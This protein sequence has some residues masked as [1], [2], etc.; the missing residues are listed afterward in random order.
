MG[1]PCGAEWG[2][3]CDLSPEPGDAGRAT[4]EPGA[5]HLFVARSD[6]EW[7]GRNPVGSIKT[8]VSPLCGDHDY[9]ELAP[10]CVRPGSHPV[11]ARQ[12]ISPS[13]RP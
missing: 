9:G 8:A 1:V 2:T 12:R 6:M 13:R 10:G 7:F 11:S 3:R 5:G 4:R